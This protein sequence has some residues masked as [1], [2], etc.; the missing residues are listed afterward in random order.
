MQHVASHLRALE[1]VRFRDEHHPLG[2]YYVNEQKEIFVVD[3]EMGD[4]EWPA[5]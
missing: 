4:S 3:F 5:K 1:V 2:V